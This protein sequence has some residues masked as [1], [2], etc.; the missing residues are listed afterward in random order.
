[1]G[2][3]VEGGDISGEDDNAA[4]RTSSLAP[5]RTIPCPPSARAEE[6][7]REAPSH[8]VLSEPL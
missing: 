1:M 8:E 3:D 5:F 4:R 7:E 6:L 2:E